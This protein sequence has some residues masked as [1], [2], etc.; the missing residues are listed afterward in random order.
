[1]IGRRPNLNRGSQEEIK[2]KATRTEL[3][4]RVNKE[5]VI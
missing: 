3:E 2:H 5:Q 1:M 4:R